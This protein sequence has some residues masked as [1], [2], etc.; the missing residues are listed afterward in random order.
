MFRRAGVAVTLV[1]RSR[2]LPEA[3][4]EI[5][6]ALQGYF[7]DE[8]MKVVSGT[9]YRMIR[10]TPMGVAFDLIHDGRPDTLEAERVLVA[11]G[12][13]ANTENLG[14]A[15]LGIKLSTNRSIVVDDHMQT[16]RADAYAAGDVTGR[17]QFV[18][19]AAYGAKLA[20]KTL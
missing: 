17:D 12:R 7:A 19:M 13:V 4:P 14:L 11:T 3:E 5:G 10:Q 16:T 8:G 6:A 15:E 2:L 18:Y 9:A 20:A 1:F